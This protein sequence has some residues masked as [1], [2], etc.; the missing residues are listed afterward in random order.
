M[1]FYG[2]IPDV[3]ESGF[4]F[5]GF[6]NNFPNF[7]LDDLLL[8]ICFNISTSRGMMPLELY[9]SEPISN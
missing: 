6:G 1:P 9:Y 8:S 3:G 5:K 2:E 7:S 4:L